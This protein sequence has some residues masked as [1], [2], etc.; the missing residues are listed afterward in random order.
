MSVSSAVA[1]G[2]T[3]SFAADRLHTLAPDWGQLAVTEYSWCTLWPELHRRLQ[4][5]GFGQIRGEEE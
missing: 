5:A 2:S 4:S 3:F 1:R